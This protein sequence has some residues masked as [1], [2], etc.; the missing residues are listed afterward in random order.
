MSVLPLPRMSLIVSNAWRLHI[1]AQDS[2]PVTV[3]TRVRVTAP[4]LDLDK[5]D[6]TLPGQ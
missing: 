4:E 5:Y 6:G 3:G 1:S 2:L